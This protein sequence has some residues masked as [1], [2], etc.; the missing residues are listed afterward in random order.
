MTARTDAIERLRRPEYTGDNRCTPCTVVNLAI[1]AAV[2]VAVGVA[3]PPPAGPRLGVA[4]LVA[5]L[6]AIYFRG[7]LVPGT[8]WFTRTY[9]PDRLLRRFEK[10]PLAG[11]NG[12]F[13]PAGSTVV[14]AADVEAVLRRGGVLA[15]CDDVDDL[16]LTPTFRAA[17]RERV[18]RLRD[19][20]ATRAELATVLDVDAPRIGVD[21]Y[22]SAFVA[23]V[24]GRRVGQWESKAAFVADVAAARAMA[25]HVDGWADLAVEDRGRVLTAVRL[26]LETCPS[27][28]GPV[29]LEEDVVESC[30]RSVDVA[31]ASCTDCGA[32]LFE[33]ELPAGA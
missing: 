31:A 22:G 11:Q 24:D 4:V 25:D 27:C 8:P 23:H 14:D 26:F 1:A 32:R 5:S 13:D 10:G 16:C 28:G 33:T 18:D 7:Y 21:D 17:W 6:G 12:G 19:D 15:E 3:V 20:D 2:A 9:F 29:T 30:C